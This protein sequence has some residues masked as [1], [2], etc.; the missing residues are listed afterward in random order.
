MALLREYCVFPLFVFN[1]K[2]LVWDPVR[3]PA[4]IDEALGLWNLSTVAEN[5]FIVAIEGPQSS[6]KSEP[7]FPVSLSVAEHP[8]VR[9]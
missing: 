8:Q 7:E 5:Y 9:P 2:P 4:Q 1:S 6:G 3:N